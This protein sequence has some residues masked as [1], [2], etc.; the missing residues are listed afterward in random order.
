MTITHALCEYPSSV[1]E[2]PLWARST[3]MQGLA[4]A[5]AAAPAPST[6]DTILNA[7][8]TS[9]TN[10]INPTKA[11]PVVKPSVAP[12][13]QDNTL[14][15]CGLGA[16]GLLGLFLLMRRGG[17]A[18]SRRRRNPS[19]L[20]IRK[21]SVRENDRARELTQAA[22]HSPSLASWS[23]AATAFRRCK[24]ARALEDRMGARQWRKTNPR[25]SP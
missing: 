23:A 2:T 12:R 11:A 15:Y 9:I 22:G 16:A 10:L 6:L 17:S 8:T 3:A 14:L 5:A 20:F 7:A 13:A 4:D 24:R 1:E 25:F 21:L 19:A 18:P